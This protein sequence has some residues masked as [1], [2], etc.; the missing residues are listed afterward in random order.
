MQG[1]LYQWLPHPSSERTVC[2]SDPL[3]SFNRPPTPK[4]GSSSCLL[5]TLSASSLSCAAAFS[6][7]HS[8]DDD[9]L[10]LALTDLGG[11]FEAG[12]VDDFELLDSSRASSDHEL[13]SPSSS[14]GS[15]EEYA[16]LSSLSS[17][18]SPA[19]AA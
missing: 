5:P 7:F 13:S 1:S 9:P 18:A 16:S 19:S 3:F 8:V 6:S 12:A 10:G 4:L 2:A 15:S 17:T 14:T 11:S